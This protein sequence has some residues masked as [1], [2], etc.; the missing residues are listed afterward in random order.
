ME[1]WEKQH[2][3]STLVKIMEKVNNV[4]ELGEPFLRHIPD[5]PFP[6]RSLVQGMA[7]LLQLGKVRIIIF[8]V[9]STK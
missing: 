6:A 7:H 1:E 9:G 8:F 5:S 3:E 4:I 2:P